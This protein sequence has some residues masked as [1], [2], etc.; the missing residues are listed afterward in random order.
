MRHAK[1]VNRKRKGCNYYVRLI[2]PYR[3]VQFCKV[4]SKYKRG[5][6]GPYKNKRMAKK[7]RGRLYR[8]GF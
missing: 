2:R 6:W 8:G 1:R 7:V 5:F 4:G 3:I